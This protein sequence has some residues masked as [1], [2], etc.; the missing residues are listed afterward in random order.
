MGDLILP[1]MR[2]TS[3]RV[4]EYFE[5]RHATVIRAINTMETSAIFNEHNFVLITYID[6][7]GRTQTGVEM[8][9][10][11]FSM[12]AMGFTGRK[13]ASWKEKF[14]AAFNAMEA[15]HKAD[16]EKMDWKAARLGLASARRELTDVV[17]EFV[18]YATAQ[19]SGSASRYYVNITKMEYKALGLLEAQK[20]AVGNFRDTLDVLDIAHLHG[21]EATAK[22]ALRLGM[23]QS[24]PYKEIYILA[25]QKVTEYADVLSFAKLVHNPKPK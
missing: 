8:T 16:A 22:E 18:D 10:D 9:R 3:M 12:L 20:T 7:R 23:E 17:K 19:G 21:A 1:S 24:I 2:T 11:G 14:L 5:I 25:R 13:A 4:A 15:K 6:S